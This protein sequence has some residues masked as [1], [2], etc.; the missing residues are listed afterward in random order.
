MERLKDFLDKLRGKRKPETVSEQEPIA[1][2]PAPKRT[3]TLEEIAGSSLLYKLT[4]RETLLVVLTK[5]LD[6]HGAGA[7]DFYLRR[8]PH[9]LSIYRKAML[10]NDMVQRLAVIPHRFKLQA[11]KLRMCRVMMSKRWCM[12]VC[13]CTP[14]LPDLEYAEAF[15]YLEDPDYEL[16]DHVTMM[17]TPWGHTLVR[18]VCLKTMMTVMEQ[19]AVNGHVF[20][21]LKPP[22]HSGNYELIRNAPINKDSN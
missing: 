19:V 5:D 3:P 9:K 7:E 11:G 12:R 13:S 2:E 4:P 6:Y 15:L 10:L 22:Q 17:L 16:V 20:F 1:E 18:D 21:R 8:W 14:E